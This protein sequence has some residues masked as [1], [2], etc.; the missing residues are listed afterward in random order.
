MRVVVCREASR[1]DTV[2]DGE[3]KAQRLSLTCETAGRSKA[4]IVVDSEAT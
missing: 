1:V 2:T 4:R 3:W